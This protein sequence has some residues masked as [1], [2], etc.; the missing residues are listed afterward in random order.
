MIGAL[1]LSCVGC[2]FVCFVYIYYRDIRSFAFRLVVYMSL[3]DIGHAVGFFLPQDP[4]ELC[5]IQA[6]ITS[7]FSL[8]SVLWTAA[9]SYTLYH[10]V[11]R[12][13]EVAPLEFK[14]L[15]FANGVS[16]LAL[17]PPIVEDSYGP[18]EGWCWIQDQGKNYVSGTFWRLM[19][20]Y[21][22]LWIVIVFNL[23]VYIS[24]IR[25]LN[26]QVQLMLLPDQSAARLVSRLKLYPMILIGCYFLPTINRIYQIA[27]HGCS[28]TPLV[29]ASGGTMCLCGF[30]NAIVYGFTD[31]VKEKLMRC[32]QSSRRPSEV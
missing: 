9:I 13:K 29:V 24:V 16:F 22:P 4:I 14:L 19:T 21:V 8:A 20:F 30:F 5:K 26:Q 15:F 6:A 12:R 10:A 31:S 1:A 7:Y 25:F 17:V 27:A 32:M 11:V 3:M 23:F 18:S 28:W 2:C